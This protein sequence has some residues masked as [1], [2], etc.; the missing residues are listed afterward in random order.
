MNNKSQ[1]IAA[2]EVSKKFVNTNGEGTTP[3]VLE[4]IQS[5]LSEALQHVEDDDVE[6]LRITLDEID[7]QEVDGWDLTTDVREYL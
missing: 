7:S 3:E 1:I 2:L 6:G 4:E 5:L